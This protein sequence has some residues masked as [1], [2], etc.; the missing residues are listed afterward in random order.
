M[1]KSISQS[2]EKGGPTKPILLFIVFLSV[3]S[4]SINSRTITQAA[5]SLSSFTLS[6]TNAPQQEDVAQPVVHIPAF[7]WG[8][9]PKAGVSLE[10]QRKIREGILKMAAKLEKATYTQNIDGMVD[11]ETV[12][13]MECYVK[14]PAFKRYDKKR[15]A[16]LKE[17]EAPTV[18]N[19]L[20]K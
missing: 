12:E 8:T 9:P 2:R 15:Q 3:A 20:T 6:R 11:I 16:C 19:W 18:A 13:E 14:Y 5:G 17:L 7:H 4:V 1:A 10:D